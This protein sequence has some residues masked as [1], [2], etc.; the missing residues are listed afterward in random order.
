MADIP[1]TEP[2]VFTAGDTLQFTRS[3]ADY[4]ASAGWVLSYTLI[5]ATTKIS[6]SASASGDDHLVNV[7][8][9]TTAGWAA[10][11]YSWLAR[12]T[13]TSEVYTVGNG[14]L[15]ILPNI[16][17]VGVTALDGRSDARVILDG[18]MAAYK[19]HVAGGSGHVAEYEIAGRKMKFRSAA[20]ILTQ[21]EH[22]KT[23]VAA[24]ERAERINKGQKAGNRILVRF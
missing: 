11:D 1:S 23:I 22:W 15:S 2:A 6:F 20:E 16:A 24:E 21:I 17:A 13:K 19:T 7:A 3:L 4:P 8:A 14:T 10:G 5:N 18:L 9:A 12:V